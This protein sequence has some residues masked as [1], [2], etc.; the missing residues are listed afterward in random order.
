M[1]A[2]E[3]LADLDSTPDGLSEQ[4]AQR[5]L[6]RHGPNR[7]PDIKP[8]GRLQRLLAQ[9]HNVLIYVLL[10]AAAVTLVLQHWIDAAVI[11]GVVVVN[12][13]TG[14]VQEGKA[15]DALAAIRNMLSPRTRHNAIRV[16]M[17]S[18]ST[19]RTNSWR[20]CTT[21]T[22]DTRSRCSK[23][24]RSSCSRAVPA[25]A[26]GRTPVPCVRTIGRRRSTHWRA[27]RSAGVPANSTSPMSSPDCS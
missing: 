15:E 2:A 4:E 26:S 8:R 11:L 18:R 3:V 24:H 17:S 21:V 14:F 13:V 23:A 6:A 10:V 22:T 1:P 25:R 7:L 20:H 9:F 5:R 16:P 12:A 19:V 27:K